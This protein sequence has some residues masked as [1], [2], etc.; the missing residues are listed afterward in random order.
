M[1]KKL[2]IVEDDTRTSLSS[3]DPFRFCIT[4][5]D[6]I[7]ILRRNLYTAAI[8]SYG[9]YWFDLANAGWFGDPNRPEETADLW[10]TLRDA[11]HAI[12]KMNLPPAAA[13]PKQPSALDQPT[14]ASPPASTPTEETMRSLMLP[15]SEIAVFFDEESAF[16]QVLNSGGVMVNMNGCSLPLSLLVLLFFLRR[17]QGWKGREES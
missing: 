1:R 6:T 9:L 14:P 16:T 2:W 12:R 5:Q 15:G 8:G 7:D 4:M 10:N 17:L 13:K 3:A 11:R